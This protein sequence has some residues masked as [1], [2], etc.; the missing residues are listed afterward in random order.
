M[1]EE[2]ERIEHLRQL[3]RDVAAKAIGE[4]AEVLEAVK[5]L[6]LRG[7]KLNVTIG[8]GIEW[9]PPDIEAAEAAVRAKRWCPICS[10]GRPIPWPLLGSVVADRV[11]AQGE[12]EVICGLQIRWRCGMCGYGEVQPLVAQSDLPPP[13][14]P[15]VVT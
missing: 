10:P 14:P 8:T 15:E 1:P 3:V 13:A 9:Q 12:R 6:K 11:A 4:S 7:Y 2:D 5:D